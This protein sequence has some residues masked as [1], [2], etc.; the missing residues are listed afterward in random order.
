M[1]NISRRFRNIILSNKIVLVLNLL[2]FGFVCLIYLDDGKALELN[3]W[4]YVLVSMTDHYYIL[5][6]LVPIITIVISKYLKSM[7]DMEKIRYGNYRRIIKKEVMG[8]A[9]WIILYFSAH[10]LVAFLIG[11]SEFRFQVGWSVL[12]GDTGFS[13]IVSLLDKYRELV[14]SPLL[15]VFIVL[16]YYCWGFVFWISFLSIIKNRFGMNYFIK[17]AITIF[18]LTVVGFRTRLMSKFPI[19]FFSNYI[20]FHHGLFVSG[21]IAF[22]SILLIGSAV[23]FYSVHVE[24]QGHK[25]SLPV[26]ELILK[27]NSFSHLCKIVLILLAI[28]VAKKLYEQSFDSSSLLISLF[29][30]SDVHYRNFISWSKISI[31]YLAPIFFI[32]FSKSNIGMYRELPIFIRYKNINELGIKILFGY[33]TFIMKYVCVVFGTI[34]LGYLLDTYFS[35]DTEA[36]LQ[37]VG[38]NG[39]YYSVVL[40]FLFSFAINLFFRFVC[41]M[42]LSEKLEESISFII[43]I[44][45]DFVAFITPTRDVILL[46]VGL[47]TL[48]GMIKDNSFLLMSNIVLKIIIIGAYFISK[49]RR[50]YGNH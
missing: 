39:N 43:L 7:S 16:A 26:N 19:L 2:I 30:G 38:L 15:S 50:A 37:E 3:L 23:I 14:S 32:G 21:E 9:V 29:G 31:F 4:E 36:F 49:Y 11:L 35:F 22:L 5:L 41:F 33:A 18:V 48:T 45:I 46:N 44:I 8:F 34:C 47:L 13:D 17:V 6:F 27:K 40:L 25:S 42:F 28:E 10:V 20:I 1:Q 24:E 12:N